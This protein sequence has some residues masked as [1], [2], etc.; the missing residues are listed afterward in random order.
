MKP[1]RKKQQKLETISNSFPGNKRKIRLFDDRHGSLLP[2]KKM[3]GNS[4]NSG[5]PLFQN[6]LWGHK[7]VKD[8]REYFG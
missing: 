7:I 8:A 5:L 1:S 4:Q 2:T 3:A 6:L